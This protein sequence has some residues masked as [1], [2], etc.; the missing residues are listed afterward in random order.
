MTD[1]Q[2]PVADPGPT[3]LD[4]HEAYKA[5]FPGLVERGQRIQD[6]R[7]DLL[8]LVDKA[9]RM[10]RRERERV[11]AAVDAL[12]QRVEQGDLEF[13]SATDQAALI[14]QTLKEIR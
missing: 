14:R 1:Q 8:R 6:L 10:R 11:L 5:L 2:T 7:A 12:A 4:Y 13:L 3:G 9:A